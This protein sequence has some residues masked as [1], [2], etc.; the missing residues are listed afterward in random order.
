MIARASDREV[1][2]RRSIALLGLLLILL[3]IGPAVGAPGNLTVG[4]QPRGEEE[5]EAAEHAAAG[6]EAREAGKEPEDGEEREAREAEPGPAGAD[7]WFTA[8]RLYPY[9]ARASL[10]AD[11]RAATEQAVQSRRAASTAAV[12]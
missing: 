10:D 12:A 5:E 1:V 2:M 8:Q 6:A 3:A 9:S 4:P 7:Q 11:Y